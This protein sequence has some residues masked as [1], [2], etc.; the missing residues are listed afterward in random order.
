ML[1]CS[2]DLD[3]GGTQTG[4]LKLIHSDVAIAVVPS[5]FP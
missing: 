2:I 1:Q 3:K 4:Y 5:L